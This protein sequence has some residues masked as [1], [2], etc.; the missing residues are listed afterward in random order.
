[1]AET[2]LAEIVTVAVVTAAAIVAET[3]AET[4]TTIDAEIVVR[5]EMQ[6]N[7]AVAREDN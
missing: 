3:V 4:A 2:D 6:A 7:H 1:V 5:Q